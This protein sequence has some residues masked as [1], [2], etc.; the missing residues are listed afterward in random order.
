MPSPG[1]IYVDLAGVLGQL[2]LFPPLGLAETRWGRL[3]LRVAVLLRSPRRV[4][5]THRARRGGRGPRAW[6][7]G[8]ASEDADGPLPLA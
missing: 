4:V 5:A 2:G 1:G 3:G 8:A 6:P 7:G